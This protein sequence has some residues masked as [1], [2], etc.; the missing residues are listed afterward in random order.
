MS[1]GLD[2]RRYANEA[3]GALL[4]FAIAV[5]AVAVLQGG[6]V[7]RWLNPPATL[8]IILPEQGLFGLSAGA[9]VE[10]LG[11]T[12]GQVTRIVIDPNQSF[13]AEA[14]ISNDMRA[15]VRRDS[16][17]FI[18][19]QF[20]IAGA[21]YLEITRGSGEPLDWD[22]AVIQARVDRAPTEDLGALITDLRERI[23]PIIDQTGRAV[24][25]LA[26][27]A[28]QLRAPDGPLNRVLAD[29]GRITQQLAEG[30]GAV[31]ALIGDERLAGET[32]RA[33]AQV[34]EA[35]GRVQTISR[36]LEQVARNLRTTSRSVSDQAEVVPRIVANVDA[37]LASLKGVSRDLS[38]ATP[39]LPALLAQTQQTTLELEQLL[40]QLRSLWV[41]GAAA[42]RKAAPIRGC[43]PWRP[44][45][46][47]AGARV[48]PRPGGT[49]RLRRQR[50]TPAGRSGAG[51]DPASRPARLRAGPPRS[52][53]DPLPP[54][55]GSC[56]AT[57]R[58]AGDRRHRLQPRRR[59]AP[60][61][62][63]GRRPRCGPPDRRRTGTPRRSRPGRPGTG[64]GG[65][66]LPDRRGDGGGAI[67]RTRGG[68]PR[69]LDRDR[70]PG[71]LPHR[72]GG[73]RRGRHRGPDR[74]PGGNGRPHD[75]NPI[76]RGDRGRPRRAGRPPGT[77]AGDGAAAEAAFVRAADRRRQLLDD[78]GMARALALAAKA[79]EAQG[80]TATAADFYL[81][82]GR[83]AAL[84]AD[85]GDAERWLERARQLAL[86]SATPSVAGEAEARLAT[87]RQA[88]N[89]P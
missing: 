2:R 44:G 5:L 10:I 31:G 55:T 87:L 3:V 73:R 1:R 81:R 14:E 45:R 25:A 30:R 82:A 36:D 34:S 72:P 6:I 17:A 22:F 62:A 60:S 68:S 43:R 80:E 23:V 37:S 38:Q 85:T 35:A 54:G 16:A 28:T 53:G 51:A 46:E 52:G 20:G 69:C 39:A 64:G 56:L 21:A 74:G 63:A 42:S 58:P 15:F 33:V 41:L 9:A 79:C 75:R 24:T 86:Q 27:V 59:R 47:P 12:A 8:K 40:A 13:Y 50:A 70:R 67:G 29:V 76:H 78:R 32:R 88:A 26:D 48:A 71:P 11:T 7:H 83:S 84:S 57:R 89:R 61:W 4:L 65:R 77:A 49:H 19:K 18:R 66:P